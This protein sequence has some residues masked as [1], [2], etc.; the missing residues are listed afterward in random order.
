MRILDLVTR[1]SDCPLTRNS[2]CPLRLDKAQAPTSAHGPQG[3]GFHFMVVTL[4]RDAGRTGRGSGPIRLTAITVPVTMTT[5]RSQEL[6]CN[7]W[8]ILGLARYP[9]FDATGRAGLRAALARVRLISY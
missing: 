5:P 6:V 7:P 9:T 2:D 3:S 4:P 8:I 1:N